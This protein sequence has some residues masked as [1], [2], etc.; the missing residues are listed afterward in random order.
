MKNTVLS[1]L[2]ACI[3]CIAFGQQYRYAVNLNIKKDQVPVVLECPAISQDEILFSF[4]KTVPGTYAVLDYGRYITAFKATDAAGK[5]LVVKKIGNNDFRISGARNLKKISYLVADSWDSGEQK[6]KIF[7]PAG[8]GF[9]KGEYFVLNN[10]ALFGAFAG[11]IHLPYEITFSKPANMTGYSSMKGR[12]EAAT[13]S[14]SAA[15]Y[16]ALMDN[17][18]LF[19]TQQPAY[20]QMGNCRITIASYY[21]QDSASYY[22]EKAVIESF[23]AIEKFTEKVPVEEYTVLLFI[24]NQQKAGKILQSGNFGLKNMLKLKKL[25]GDHAYGALEHPTSSLYFLPDFG[26]HS[27]PAMLKEVVIHEFMHI[28]TP[29]NLHSQ[30]IGD[31][32]Y[33]Q[34]IM[35]KHLWLY[36]GITEYFAIQIR[37]Q[38]GLETVEG[39]LEQQLKP[40]IVNAATYPD[41]IP[42]TVMSAHVFDDPYKDLYSQVYERGAIMGMLL[43]FEIMRLTAGKMTL[44]TAVFELCKR[45]GPHK[46]FDEDSFIQEF[47]TLVHPDLQQ[48]FDRYVTGTQHLGLDQGFETVGIEFHEQR[49]GHVPVDLLNKEESGAEANKNIVINGMVTITTAN[50]GNTAGFQKE[51]QVSLKGI[52]DA[53]K[54][55]AGE[56]VAEGEMIELQ[57]LR[58]KQAVTLKFPAKYKEGTI[59][60]EFRILPNPSAQQKRL[61]DLWTTGQ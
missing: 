23:K 34:P 24:Q 6:N 50:A 10:G 47:V 3:T 12:K 11:M 61:F 31:F 58:N 19:T 4:P 22:T 35:S 53:Y 7:E 18:I 30:Y 8:S 17:P 13:E 9:E 45:Y 28:Y 54:N 29:L 55:E 60:N 21:D 41:S 40:K 44:K 14:Y 46:S 57:I 43:D 38:G 15:D 56:F 16:H 32:N 42:F 51:D 1:L 59:R 48:F 26:G 5:K 33:Q 52:T 37:M 27:Y 49:T 39:T 36:E 2:A 20:Y 25:I